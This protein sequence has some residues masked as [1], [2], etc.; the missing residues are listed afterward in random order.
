MWSCNANVA[1]FLN[2]V[3]KEQPEVKMMCVEKSDVEMNDSCGRETSQVKIN[4]QTSPALWLKVT[5]VVRNLH[6]STPSQLQ[7]GRRFGDAEGPGRGWGCVVHWGCVIAFYLKG[8]L[9]PAQE[10]SI[11]HSRRVFLCFFIDKP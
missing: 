11:G 7:A 8:T 3:K 5:T 2:P 6:G 4:E 9:I 1:N 10:K